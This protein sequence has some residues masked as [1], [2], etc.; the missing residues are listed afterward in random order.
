MSTLAAVVAVLIAA[1]GAGLTAL[2]AIE[3]RWSRVRADAQAEELYSL[4]E[5]FDQSLS[6]Y[7]ARCRDFIARGRESAPL[8]EAGWLDM[9]RDSARARTLVSLYFPNLWPQVK[10]TDALL[11]Q[12]VAALR[13]YAGDPRDLGSA[14]AFD[15]SIEELKDAMDALKSAVVTAHRGAERRRPA[16]PPAS[17]PGLNGLRPAA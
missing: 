11:S 14:R 4:V 1:A 16:S 13:R 8:E 17:P 3:R 6:A 9:R 15:R 2:R 7:L 5:S 12:A 10:R